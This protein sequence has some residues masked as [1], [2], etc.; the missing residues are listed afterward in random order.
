MDSQIPPLADRDLLT[1]EE[2]VS[3]SAVEEITA[4]PEEK[5]SQTEAA[6]VLAEPPQKEMNQKNSFETPPDVMAT[7]NLS[8]AKQDTPDNAPSA[9]AMLKAARE[10]AG[11]SIDEVS[12]SLKL[13]PRQIQAL[14][15]QIFTALPARAFV[16]G[17]VRNYARLLN[18]DADAVLA[19][20]P[21]EGPQ[22]ISL[23]ASSVKTPT[24]VMPV[25]HPYGEKTV[26]PQ[27]WKWLL[28]IVVLAIIATV[29]FFWSQIMALFPKHDAVKTTHDTVAPIA[30]GETKPSPIQQDG[31]N[32]HTVTPI[33]TPLSE[34]TADPSQN[35]STLASVETSTR[36][37]T[38][39]AVVAAR[40]NEEAELVLRF[41]GDSWAEVRDKH[42]R[43]IYYELAKKGS[44]K[45]L[46]GAPPFSLVLG[47]SDAV[48]VTL[49]GEKI[50]LNDQNKQQG[51]S[52]L[53]LE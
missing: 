6:S 34:T 14:E 37:T 43:T 33:I 47:N 3:L 19:A 46:L 27:T 49:R 4:A 44:E 39:S 32:I 31:E 8:C 35:V 38:E 52:R 13:V 28:A 23:A 11:L 26:Q 40:N 20:L 41:S 2:A 45:T 42:G 24:R 29:F 21:P 25:L 53:T 17:F 16:R 51:V 10:A 12:H 22:T 48:T 30:V 50:D 18:I 5:T 1:S 15:Q 36:S 9:G 7:E